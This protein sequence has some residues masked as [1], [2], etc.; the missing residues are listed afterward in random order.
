MNWELTK[1]RPKSSGL[2]DSIFFFLAFIIL[3]KVANRGSATIQRGAVPR[4]DKSIYHLVCQGISS[5]H[6]H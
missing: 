2:S 3:G 6:S 1:F 4:N 5:I